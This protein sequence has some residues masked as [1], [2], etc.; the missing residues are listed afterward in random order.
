MTV[1]TLTCVPCVRG[2]ET[3]FN[4]TITYTVHT[5]LTLLYYYTRAY[6]SL[7]Y[8]RIH[9]STS[10]YTTPHHYLSWWRTDIVHILMAKSFPS[11]ESGK[12]EL[13]KKLDDLNSTAERDDEDKYESEPGEGEAGEEAEGAPN[14]SQLAL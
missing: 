6:T 4:I 13:D 1:A 9:S 8:T 14:D 11:V 12:D 2:H 5:M 3:L 7:L 10:L